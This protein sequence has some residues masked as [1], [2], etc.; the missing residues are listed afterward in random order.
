[1]YS[2]ILLCLDY[3]LKRFV[4]RNR[5]TKVTDFSRHV[6]EEITGAYVIEQNSVIVV[7]LS[8]IVGF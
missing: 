2:G 8:D 5:E 7:Q 1:M 4:T 3:L 6:R